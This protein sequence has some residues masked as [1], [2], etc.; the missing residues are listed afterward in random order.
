MPIQGMT[1]FRK[2]QFGKQS[3]LGTGVAATRRIPFRGT[4][5]VNPNWTDQD[6]VDV[7]SIDPVLPAYRT[8][9][10]VTASLTATLDFHHIPMLLSAGLIGDV[11][12]SAV[13]GGAYTWTH[14]GVSLTAT[15]L[16]Y[17]TTEW[18]DDVDAD[19][20]DA[21]D[22]IVESL[23]FSFDD[24][25]GPWNV[26][27]DWR[28]GSVDHGVTPTAALNV[29]SNLPLLFGADTELYIDD[30]SGAIGS[31]KITDALHSATIR[32]DN[33][34][35]VKRFA[36]GSNS[37]FQVDGYGLSGREIM[38]SF[39]FA[40]TDAII[41]ALDSEVTDWLNA[42][43]VNRYVKVLVQSTQEAETGTPY[44]WDL[45]LSGTWRTRDDGELGGNSTVTLEMKGR[46]DAALTYPIRSVV[47]NTLAA[48][49]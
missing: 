34:I 16:E 24:D 35:D 20:Y 9:T 21:I 13:G 26:S 29:A 36:N 3:S 32:I 5:D 25:L 6:E 14:T 28:F 12:G 47:T 23:E 44:S 7:G 17:F 22:G 46:Y 37:R 10:D 30:T 8:Q 15:E 2:W 41:G 4:L 48:L 19:G 40:K 1:R 45:R 38:A 39:T 11:S 42:D 31:T 18:A 33:E 43:P 27:A 49:P